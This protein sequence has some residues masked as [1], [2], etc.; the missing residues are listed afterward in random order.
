MSAYISGAVWLSGPQERNQRFVLLAIADNSNE[1]GFAFPSTET[2]ASKCLMSVRYVLTTLQEL[3][4]EG[5]LAI[6]RNDPRSRHSKGNSYQ[7][8]LEKLAAYK[9]NS[10]EKSSREDSSRELGST[11][12]VNS[13]ANSSE[14]GGNAIRKNRHR[15]VIKEPSCKTSEI[16]KQNRRVFP[17]LYQ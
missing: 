16:E 10:S 14:L 8:V 2:L 11:T 17:H 6:T 1:T 7:I 15:T 3:E 9:P 4:T 5:W 13:V 12:Q